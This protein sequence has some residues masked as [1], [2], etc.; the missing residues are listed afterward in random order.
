[1]WSVEQKLGHSF[2]AYFVAYLVILLNSQ[3]AVAQSQED[4]NKLR[5]ALLEPAA[6][7]PTGPFV[8]RKGVGRSLFRAYQAA[9]SQHLGNACPY[10]PD[11]QIYCRQAFEY[12]SDAAALALSLDRLTRCNRLV[13]LLE[14]AR[15]HPLQDGRLQD[16]LP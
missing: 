8:Q 1:M 3:T 14:G 4:L 11:C 16:P 13:I 6:Y 7:I 12:K 15:W 10:V 9:F 2:V 5:Q